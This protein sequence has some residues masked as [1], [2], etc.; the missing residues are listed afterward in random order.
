MH[1][2]HSSL[3]QC[4]IPLADHVMVAASLVIRREKLKRDTR[5]TVDCRL[6]SLSQAF[7]PKARHRIYQAVDAH[8]GFV[9]D[10]WLDRLPASESRQ[11]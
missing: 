7:R 1:F 5:N 11:E 6:T 10:E 9:S 2:E 3:E 8:L 4:S